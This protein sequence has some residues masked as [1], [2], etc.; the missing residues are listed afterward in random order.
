MH[1]TNAITKCGVFTAR[2]V[3]SPHKTDTFR[4]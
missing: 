4:M 1:G 2:Y 3:L